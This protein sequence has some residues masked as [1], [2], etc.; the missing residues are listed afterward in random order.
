MSEPTNKKLYEK[1]KKEI[2]ARHPEHSA[3]R[4]GLLVKEYKAMGGEYKGKKNKNQGL[5]RWFK[6]KWQ[7]QRGDTGYK[8]KSDVYRPTIRVTKDTPTTFKELTK[9]QI[10]KARREKAKTG[11]V[12][13]FD[14]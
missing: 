1:V 2:Y 8:H 3:Y 12:S 14:K 7:S 6:E 4:S 10:E 13:K 9:T 5:D 11:R